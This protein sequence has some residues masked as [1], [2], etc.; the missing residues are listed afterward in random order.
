M[1]ILQSL[2]ISNC[3]KMTAE[4]LQ[5]LAV[6]TQLTKLIA[7][8]AVLPGV[9]PVS[10]IGRVPSIFFSLTGDHTPW[11]VDLHAK[12]TRLTLAARQ[13]CIK[14]GGWSRWPL[15]SAHFTSA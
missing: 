4:G 12:P 5:G 8:N 1:L 9:G 10:F 14:G 13:P 11:A 2:D 15:S 3:R 7:Y 6:L